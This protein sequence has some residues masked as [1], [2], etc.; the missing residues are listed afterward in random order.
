MI[1]L[2][3]IKERAQAALAIANKV[4]E[5]GPRAPE[6]TGHIQA[7]INEFTLA[8]AMLGLAAD[9]SVEPCT[10]EQATIECPELG[11]VLAQIDGLGAVDNKG[12]FTD[13][14]TQ[15]LNSPLGPVL[16]QM[17]MA[18]LKIPTTP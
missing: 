4:L 10:L 14:L 1:N 12:R 6:F 7:G 5:F 17:L 9:A 15:L 2:T 3:T 13:L 11:A 8:A 16:M 18:W